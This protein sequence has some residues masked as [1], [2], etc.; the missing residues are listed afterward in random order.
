MANGSSGVGEG[1]GGVAVGGA[2]GGGEGGVAGHAIHL[3]YWAGISFLERQGDVEAGSRR[4]LRGN[5]SAAA[6]EA[7][8]SI[9]RTLRCVDADL[10]AGLVCESGGEL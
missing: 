2:C 4:G 5:L 1:V 9:A 3:A 8:A 6:F 10:R 7:R